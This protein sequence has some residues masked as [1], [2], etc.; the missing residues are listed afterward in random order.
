MK[1]TSLKTISVSDIILFLSL[2]LVGSFNEYI[3]C[4]ISVVLLLIFLVRTL[5]YKHLS[6]NF[7]LQFISVLAIVVFYG[8]TCFWAVDSGMAFVGFLKFIPVLLYLILLHQ[9]ENTSAVEMLPYF[10]AILVVASSIGSFLPITS[11]PFLVVGRFAGFFQY[12]NTFALLLLIS[13]LLLLKNGKLNAVNAVTFIVL[14]TGLL[15]TGSRTVFVLFFVSNFIMIMFCFSKKNRLVVF[16]V[17]IS[18]IVVLILIIIFGRNVSFLNR[19]LNINFS[20]STFVGR[21]LYFVD[22]F[23]LILKYPFGMGYMGYYYAQGS[24]QTGVYSVAYVHNDFLQFVLDVGVL[25]TI[26]FMAYIVKYF[27]NKSV[28]FGSKVIVG[29]FVLHTLLDFNFQ[30][31]G[32]LMLFIL[33]TLQRNG[34][35][36]VINSSKTAFV[37]SS[38]LLSIINIYMF[39]TL[40]IA[41]FEITDLAD[42]LYPFNTRNKI[43]MLESEYDVKKAHKIADEILEQNKLYYVPYSINAKY[44]YSV[45]DFGS[46]IENKNKAFELNPFGYTEYEEYCYMLINGIDVYERMGD[47]KSVQVCE[48]ELLSAYSKLTG[49]KNRLSSLGS[50]IVDQPT[51]KLPDTILNYIKRLEA[52]QR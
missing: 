26:P 25:P 27:I 21:V 30:F 37:S 45:G 24:V 49:N 3:S 6:I 51:L 9:N 14:L 19:F 11:N 23:K 40:L 44:A 48:R 50:M 36:C 41:H 32:M 38:V 16:S 34:K 2:I 15:Y 33:L 52:E 31:V 10:S 1:F 20:E 17:F 39:V 5:R 22:A 4:L 47:K 13:E 18:L 28:D 7:N 46:L 29:T 42:K 12:P 35:E 8:L 43:I